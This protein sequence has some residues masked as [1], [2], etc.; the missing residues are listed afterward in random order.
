MS[1]SQFFDAAESGDIPRLTSILASNSTVLN[2]KDERWYDGTALMLS[3]WKGHTEIAHILVQH[4]ASLDLQMKNGGTALTLS[5][6]KGHTEIAHILVQHKA[7]LDLQTKNGFTALMCSSQEG[8]TEIAHILVQHKASLDLQ[9]KDG[10]TA[11]ILAAYHGHLEIAS[12]L[13]LNGA[14]LE[15]RQ[16]D[17]WRVVGN[18]AR[19][20]AEERGHTD[21]V[22]LIEK[23]DRWRRRRF[24]VMF[25]TAFRNAAATEPIVSPA[26]DM[27]LSLEWV[28]RIVA[29]YL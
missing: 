16:K 19:A 18:D 4:K 26:M 14:D 13:M 7:S 10:T 5:S 1:K 12:W 22:T 8:H 6:E 21:I 9:M 24:W 28:T 17:S 20:W 23:E 29:G 2:A 25:S 15:L 3:S 27:A 11:L